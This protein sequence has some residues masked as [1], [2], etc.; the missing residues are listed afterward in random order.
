MPKQPVTLS[1]GEPQ[2]NGRDPNAYVI[3]IYESMA[4]LL[5]VRPCL[6]KLQ[7]RRYDIIIT[8]RWSV[9]VVLFVVVVVVVDLMTDA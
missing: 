4:P 5:C 2:Q 8:F 1:H 7:T 6:S 9:V 3:P